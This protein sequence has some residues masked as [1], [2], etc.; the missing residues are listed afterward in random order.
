MPL[1]L[2]ILLNLS[3]AERLIVLQ[4]DRAELFLL[5]GVA[6]GL[7][8][9]AFLLLVVVVFR[10]QKSRKEELNQEILPPMGATPNGDSARFAPAEP[11]G[12]LPEE[13]QGPAVEQSK[14]IQVE[15]SPADSAHE[16][17][18]EIETEAPTEI[19]EI[20]S[21]ETTEVFQTEPESV[22]RDPIDLESL[23]EPSASPSVQ[24]VPEAADPAFQEPALQLQAEPLPESLLAEQAA[25]AVQESPNQEV[26]TDRVEEAEE[27]LEEATEETL[28][29]A[30]EPEQPEPEA[31]EETPQEDASAEEASAEEA[32][33]EEASAEEASAE[34]AQAEEPPQEEAPAE[35]APAEETPQEE[36]PQEEAPAEETPQEE[37]PAEETPA[38]EA[39]A[40]TDLESEKE[41]AEPALQAEKQEQQGETRNEWPRADSESL[42]EKEVS[43][44]QESP[45]KAETTG[46]PNANRLSRQIDEALKGAKSPEENRRAI[47]AYLQELKQRKS[48]ASAAVQPQVSTNETEVAP[49]V[50]SKAEA[51]P[52]ESA[53]PTAE[54]NKAVL[55]LLPAPKPDS[56][57]SGEAAPTAAPIDAVSTPEETPV[58]S[59]FEV[60]W[61]E[62]QEE[63]VAVRHLPA[64]PGDLKSFADWLKEFRKP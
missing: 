53:A 61:N 20:P 23:E 28:A 17:P 15:P 35:E 56:D 43:S 9:L 24:S 52:I 55:A 42:V 49:N 10:R 26:P 33:A 54:S 40:A 64:A 3:P 29:E 34:E 38:E 13:P 41:Q 11:L 21:E 58:L 39:P 22:Q 47:D 63:S 37:A 12:R 27:M 46:N 30:I 16:L 62:V 50:Q 7:L 45:K 5:M 4:Q 60:N 48:G 14:P 31:A 19:E 57:A 44:A 8:L 36:T 6:I 1:I 25:E 18:T 32:S 2:S 59:D 51:A